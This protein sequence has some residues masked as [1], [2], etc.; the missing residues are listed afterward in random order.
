MSGSPGE[1]N[2]GGVRTKR[3]LF[4]LGVEGSRAVHLMEDLANC[5]FHNVF[6]NMFGD[7]SDR[8]TSR[9]AQQSV[10]LYI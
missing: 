6:S 7:Q 10:G 4:T 2:E 1:D 5:T 3:V 9:A 8:V